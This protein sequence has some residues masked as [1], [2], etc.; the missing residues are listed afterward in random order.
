MATRRSST[1]LPGYHREHHT[2]DG[3]RNPGEDTRRPP[4]RR[5]VA[6][7]MRRTMR[8]KG[9]VPPPVRRLR[10]ADLRTPPERLRVTWLGHATLL[11]QWP[12]C[13][14]LTDPML[15]DRASPLPFAGPPRL[16]ELPIALEALPPIDAVLV[17]HDHYDHFDRPTIKRLIRQFDPLFFAPLGVGRYLRK[18]GTNR[19]VELDWWQRAD[20]D[21]WAIYGVPARHFSGRHVH[22]RNRTLWAGWCVAPAD[23]PTLYFAGDTAYGDHFAAIRERIGAPDVA[24]LPIGA[25][26]PRRIMRPVHANPPEAAQAALDLQARHI[27]PM[28]WGTFDLA[29]EPVQ[30]PAKR[31]REEAAR[32]GLSDRLHVLNI[33]GHFDLKAQPPIANAA[34]SGED[35]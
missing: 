12:G 35:A 34:S 14:L 19:V 22:T 15:G 26:R 31:M 16:P 5:I 32:R 28:H 33:G 9:N 13:T 18:W 10:A 1:S 20:W 17:S 25:N 11:L 24:C 23:G 8:P 27:I 4:L 7:L 6:W 2:D 30:E 29:D 21:D 3:F